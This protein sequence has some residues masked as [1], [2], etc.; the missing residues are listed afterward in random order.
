MLS[1]LLAI[2][3]ILLILCYVLVWT[4]SLN[5]VPLILIGVKTTKIC[6]NC[7][8][9]LAFMFALGLLNGKCLVHGSHNV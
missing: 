1:D 3:L 2:K 8:Y 5:V 4:W 7:V 9:M 6:A